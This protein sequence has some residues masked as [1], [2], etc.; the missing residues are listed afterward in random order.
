[1]LFTW[2]NFSHVTGTIYVSYNSSDNGHRLSHNLTLTSH[3]NLWCE[4]INSNGALNRAWMGITS[5]CYMCVITYQWQ[6]SGTSSASSFTNILSI[7]TPYFLCMGVAVYPKYICGPPERKLPNTS[8]SFPE[9]THNLLSPQSS[10]PIASL[11]SELK[12]SSWVLQDLYCFL[13][14]S[15]CSTIACY[16]VHYAL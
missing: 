2:R 16:F 13:T 11:L 6:N 4:N 9:N 3:N 14:V 8:P 1:M 7:S 10:F 5:S 15:H 12:S